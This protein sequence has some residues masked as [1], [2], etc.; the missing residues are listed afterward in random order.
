MFFALFSILLRVSRRE[1]PPL[2][3]TSI[4]NEQISDWIKKHPNTVIFYSEN[5]KVIKPLKITIDEHS[6]IASF[7]LTPPNPG[8]N[9]FCIGYPCAAAYLNGTHVRSTIS[10]FSPLDFQFWISHT[11][12]EPHFDIS[13]AEELRLLLNLP[14]FHL[15]C[16]DMQHRPVWVPQEYVVF[17]STRFQFS[18]LGLSVSKGLYVF[19][20]S[21]R[22]LIKLIK[23][24]P[25][26]FT[27]NLFDIGFDSIL[28]RPF[29]AGS[30]ID[31]VSDEADK[32]KISVLKEVAKE[33]HTR[34]GITFFAGHMAGHVS[35]IAR[36][37]NI[38]GP[39]FVVLNSTDFRGPHW[40]FTN[41]ENI[42][43]ISFISGYLKNVLR[44]MKP[45][46]ITSPPQ[47]R[48]RK[49]GV[50]EVVGID[51]REKVVY[52]PLSSIII[53]TSSCA[54]LPNEYP[55]VMNAASWVYSNKSISFFAF[56]QGRN[57]NPEELTVFHS[58]PQI[59][60][61]PAKNGERRFIPFEQELTLPNFAEFI[62]V[63]LAVSIN[64]TEAQLLQEYTMQNL[65]SYDRMND[66]NGGS[67][68]NPE[69]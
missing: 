27:S 13:S 17:Y 55:S 29:L 15:I 50:N 12:S 66:G 62:K 68:M 37:S 69:L 34:F 59:L 18:K 4:T 31:H 22:E 32:I 61:Y 25:S 65:E 36:I 35:H 52:N 40:G 10:D 63:N 48:M 8:E 9:Q 67:F 24:D 54:D 38:C 6:D 26:Q 7:A 47:N 46:K 51:F 3:Y 21:D 53:V 49:V 16:V 56:D 44:G 5:A 11:I 64:E 57:E 60:A 30:F 14:G 39:L 23:W 20:H 33:A 45:N 28:S 19:R 1:R 41:M 43:N 2:N 42:H 58:Y